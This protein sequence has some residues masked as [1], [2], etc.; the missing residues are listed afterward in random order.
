[1]S[2]FPFRNLI[3]KK[4]FAIRDFFMVIYGQKLM[5]CLLQLTMNWDQIEIKIPKL[6]QISL[7]NSIKDELWSTTALTHIDTLKLI[8]YQMIKYSH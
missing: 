6:I 3:K 1:M 8:N 5:Q 7:S 2:N 4:K